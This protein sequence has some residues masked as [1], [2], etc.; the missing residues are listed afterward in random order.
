MKQTPNNILLIG[1]G[2]HAKRIY[3]HVC[4]R[5]GDAHHF[6]LVYVV[7]LEEKKQ[8]IESYLREQNDSSTL[9]YCIAPEDRTFDEL[10]ANVKERLDEI[11][12]RFVI[13]GVII[14]TE[15]LAHMVYAR[16]A[17]RKGISILMDKP[18]STKENISTSESASE[19]IINDYYELLKLYNK[20]KEK[21]GR[22]LFSIMTQRRFH[23]GYQKVKELISEVFRKTNCPV[24]SIQSFHSDGQWWMPTELVEIDYHPYNKGYGKCSHSGYHFFDIVPHLLE[25]A[26]DTEKRINNVDVFANFLRPL[27]FL[28]QLR[29]KDLAN[30]FEDFHEYNK[31]REIDLQSLY[32]YYGEIDAFSTFAF[33]CNDRTLTLGSINLVHNGFSQRGW[34]TSQGRDLYK[35]NGRVRNESHFIEQGPF[36]A[37]SL[38][39]YQSEEITPDKSKKLYSP[40]GEYHFDIHIFRNSN[41]F[42]R[43]ESHR[44]ISIRDLNKNF[45]VGTSRGHQEDARRQAVLEFA[46]FLNGEQIFPV[47]DFSTHERGVRLL[48]GVYRSAARRFI[49]KN[50][51]VNVNF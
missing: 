29:L 21:Y 9:L 26:E 39:S 16:W 33:N 7:D 4:K 6:K 50:P 5:D 46:S 42:P 35:G 43:W 14:S 48:H 1:F 23:P 31:Y 51:L 45:M 12:E 18:V 24:T 10:S 38:I 22:V 11:V 27:D 44:K 25:A 19:E 13:K 30:L 28:S 2:P 41:L 37:I 8:E 47:S 20:A 40:G 17:L 3:Y 34:V 15:P 36:Q 32:K 49:G